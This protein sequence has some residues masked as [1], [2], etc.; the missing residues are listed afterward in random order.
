MNKYNIIKY[1]IG[2]CLVLVFVVLVWLCN[3]QHIRIK[4]LNRERENQRKMIERLS[5]MSAVHCEVSVNIRNT[6]TF[7]KVVAGDVEV[8]ADQIARATRR[9]ILDSCVWLK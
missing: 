8:I 5:E 4:E 1:S 7:G 2:A 6:A 9:E 3:V